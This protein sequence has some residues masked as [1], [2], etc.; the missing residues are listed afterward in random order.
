MRILIALAVNL[1][2]LTGCNMGESDDS[3]MR[4]AGGKADDVNDD[5]GAGND[6]GTTSL[7]GNGVLDPGEQCDDGNTTNLDGCDSNCQFEQM[8]RVNSLTMEWAPSTLC[9]A[10][11]LG[12]AIK[13]AAQGTFTSKVNDAVK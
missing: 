13:S 3:A 11:A 7:C 12:G 8:H 4:G 2:V 1:L 6:G 5:G 9:P 10:N